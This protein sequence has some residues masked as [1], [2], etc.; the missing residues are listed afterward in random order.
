MSFLVWFCSK[1]SDLVNLTSSYPY[2]LAL[3]HFF[4]WFLPTSLWSSL[5]PLSTIPTF[6]QT[7]WLLCLA[8]SVWSC[9]TWGAVTS[10]RAISLKST[11]ITLLLVS[12]LSLDSIDSLLLE[13]SMD[14]WLFCFLGVLMMHLEGVKFDLYQ[15][16][17]Y[18]ILHKRLKIMKLSLQSKNETKDKTKNNENG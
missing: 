1:F 10:I 2:L 17:F 8:L 9:F 3:L 13:F 12:V 15:L 7:K 14:L 6:N 11:S 5:L 16:Y 4:H 18:K